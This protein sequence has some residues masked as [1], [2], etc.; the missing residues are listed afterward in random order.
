MAA[1]SAQAIRFEIQSRLTRH[2]QEAKEVAAT[3][4]L[5]NTI[6]CDMEEHSQFEAEQ[7]SFCQ[8]SV[9]SATHTFVFVCGC[10]IVW[11]VGAFVVVTAVAVVAFSSSSSFL[12]FL[13]CDCCRSW[14]GYV[15]MSAVI[16]VSLS[17]W[18][19]TIFIATYT[20]LIEAQRNLEEQAQVLQDVEARLV[21]S[22]PSHSLATTN[23][24]ASCVQVRNE[25]PEHSDWEDVFAA[26]QRSFKSNP[27]VQ[28]ARVHKTKEEM[29]ALHQK[30]WVRLI[31]DVSLSNGQTNLLLTASQS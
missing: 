22:L 24:W 31:G 19:K 13:L 6:A 30:I 25:L 16:L 4:S 21:C 15:R 11:L 23:C 8:T 12:H 5:I 26:T 7:V 29:R 9:P 2:Q 17:C 3:L 20:N 18:Q 10:L 27:D 1:A 14:F 28:A